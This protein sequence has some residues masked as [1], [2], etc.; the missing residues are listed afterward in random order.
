M[1]IG[2]KIVLFV[3][4]LLFFLCCTA[5]AFLVVVS[6]ANKL[7]K[8]H[9]A[10]IELN[11]SFA[12]L[13]IQ[14][15]RSASAFDLPF[16]VLLDEAI[17][18]IAGASSYLDRVTTLN[19]I[20]LKNES[21]LEFAAQLAVSFINLGSTREDQNTFETYCQYVNLLSD[22]IDLQRSIILKELPHFSGTIRSYR[23]VSFIISAG[24]IV[25]TW[26]LGL[27]LVWL[28]SR[29]V[30]RRSRHLELLLQNMKDGD[31]EKCINEKTFNS[32]DDLL[33]RMGCFFASI[34]KLVFSMQKEVS[35]N[36]DSSSKLSASLDNTSATFEIVDGFIDSIRGE[37]TILEDQ[38]KSV[39]TGLD[40]VTNGLNSL[41]AG[42]NDQKTVVE[43]SLVSVQG[44]ITAINSMAEN[45]R[46]DEEIVKTLVQS[47]EHGQQL[48]S[49]TYQKIT[50][51][52]DSIARI[53]GMASVIENIA[54]QTNMLALNA[55]IEAAHAGDQGKGFAV[56]AEEITKL[57]EASSESSRE[58]SASI[59]E[60][61]E[62]ITQMASSSTELDQ[63]F[64]EITSNIGN[65]YESIS[66]FARTL[67]HSDSD[68]KQVLETMNTLDSVSSTV[69]RDAGSMSEGAGAI[70]ASMGQ[71][72]MIS[73]RVFDGVTAL[74]LMLDGLKDVMSEF[75]DLAESMKDSGVVM[76]STL[77]QLK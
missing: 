42:I 23:V 73:S 6:P 70:A 33:N 14:M 60:I 31:V 75:K 62:N 58:I 50:L 37:V 21:L 24:I 63:A 53:N 30:S 15:H 47:S 34:Q 69:T 16:P 7:Q 55:A 35:S 51:I 25:S 5:G 13:Q 64:E 77:S 2:S 46:H 9:D 8:T 4:S 45:A 67:I 74:S 39:K 22:S 11:T 36:I 40:R 66:E 54:E 29:T 28:L 1:K 18:R 20:V 61:V 48:F 49:S 3:V 32:D 19:E 17:S 26:F 56:V 10:L 12:D 71:L 57:A 52:S 65:V 27:F 43:G 72:E 41:D 59:E 38:V 68:T 44:M 76:S